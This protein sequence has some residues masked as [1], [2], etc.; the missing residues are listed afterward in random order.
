VGIVIGLGAARSGGSNSCR[1]KKF[2]SFPKRPFR[3]WS[4]PI[5]LFNW[6]RVSFPGI[7]WSGCG[8]DHSLPSSAEVKNEW[9]H[10]SHTSADSVCLRSEDMNKFTLYLFYLKMLSS[11]SI[12]GQRGLN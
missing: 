5:F 8:V 10:T 9:S 11:V 2:F 1:G 7:E 6:Y 4:P 12:R 3:L